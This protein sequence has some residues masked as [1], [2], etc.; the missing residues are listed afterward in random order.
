MRGSL[1][2]ELRIARKNVLLECRSAAG[3]HEYEVCFLAKLIFQRSEYYL[4]PYVVHR[5][6]WW[7]ANPAL[8]RTTQ[9]YRGNKKQPGVVMHS[10]HT[11]GKVPA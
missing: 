7:I 8:S 9:G 1:S 5:F 4:V 10:V 2:L 6:E 3:M 11:K